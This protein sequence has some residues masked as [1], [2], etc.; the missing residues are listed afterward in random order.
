MSTLLLELCNG[1]Q[2]R[3]V[4]KGNFFGIVR[5]M[6]SFFRS[7]SSKGAD[8]KAMTK[9]CLT[10]EIRTMVMGDSSPRSNRRF[11]IFPLKGKQ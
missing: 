7:H 8:E 3:A 4:T 5:R 11:L 6:Q 10:W 2:A 9:Y 1:D